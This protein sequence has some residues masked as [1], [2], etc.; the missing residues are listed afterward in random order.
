MGLARVT[1]R[2]PI[3]LPTADPGLAGMES[4]EDEAENP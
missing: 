3:G 4:D 2:K 1:G